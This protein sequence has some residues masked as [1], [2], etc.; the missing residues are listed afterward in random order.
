MT[1][2]RRLALKISTAVVKYASPGC[3][4]WALGMLHEAEFIESDFSAF[5]WALGSIRVLLIRREAPI[6]SLAEASDMASKYVDERRGRVNTSW[7]LFPQSFL[8]LIN[9]FGARTPL[10]RI[11]Y[12]MAISGS[13][14][15]GIIVF[16]ERRR[17]DKLL[18]AD[19]D[20][21]VLFYKKELERSLQLSFRGVMLIL[22][23]I[24]LITGISLTLSGGIEAHPILSL[25]IGSISVMIVLLILHA[26]RVNQRRLQILEAFLQN[27][28]NRS[29]S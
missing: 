15:M 5:T 19:I 13:L 7:T 28:N 2:L 4:E 24:F 10:V 16:L 3:K 12:G 27:D 9:F 11:G 25:F 18:S 14:C 26:R 6:H 23:I 21:E 29:G 1:F 22:S 20:D 17:Q 8:F